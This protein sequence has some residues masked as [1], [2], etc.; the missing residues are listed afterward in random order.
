MAHAYTFISEAMIATGWR[1]P[2]EYLMLLGHFP[3]KSPIIRGSFAQKDL[4]LRHP[5]HV[6]NPVYAHGITSSNVT[7]T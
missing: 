1:R 7:S 6:R 3:Q 2:I 5:M 4:H